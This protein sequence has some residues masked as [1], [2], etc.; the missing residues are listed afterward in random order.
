MS[1]LQINN[2]DISYKEKNILENVNLTVEKNEIISIM[3]NSGSGKSTF[4]S[5]LNGFLSENGGQY[6]GKILF[7]GTDISQY[8]LIDLRRQISMLF[9]DSTVFD[10][11]I[12]KNL[13]Y[14]LEYFLGKNYDKKTKIEQILKSVN[15]YEELKDNL[16]MNANKLSGG[17]KQRLCIA[18]ML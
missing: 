15:L 2:L 12:E 13:T 7:D 8:K 3:G 11:S 4:L 9:Q 10:M 6:S 16:K 14:T 5:C 17:Q 1:I 18:R